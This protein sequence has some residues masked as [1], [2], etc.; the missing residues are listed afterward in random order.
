VSIPQNEEFSNLERRINLFTIELLRS[1][2]YEEMY[3][4]GVQK[5]LVYCSC[6][7][8]MRDL[9]IFSLDLRLVILP[10]FKEPIIS[11]PFDLTSFDLGY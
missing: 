10:F 8:C 6:C 5:I 4:V 11:M 7:Q 2:L 9:S 3:E 1:A